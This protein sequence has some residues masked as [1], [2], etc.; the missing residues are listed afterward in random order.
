MSNGNKNQKNERHDGSAGFHIE[1]RS[2]ITYVSIQLHGH[3][4]LHL[5]INAAFEFRAAAEVKWIMPQVP[6]F[7]QKPPIV[8]LDYFYECIF[9]L[10]HSLG[11]ISPSHVVRPLISLC[12][13]FMHIARVEH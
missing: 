11:T 10:F 6:L 3:I 13:M 9:R 7:D 5:N 8:C 12:S 1:F 4:S 2:I